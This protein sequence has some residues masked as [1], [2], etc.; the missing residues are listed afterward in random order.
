MRAAK[1]IILAEMKRHFPDMHQKPEMPLPGTNIGVQWAS[2]RGLTISGY[3]SPRGGQIYEEIHDV[4]HLREISGKM[5]F[6]LRYETQ[7]TLDV[8]RVVAN[9]LTLFYCEKLSL[10]MLD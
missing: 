10:Y 8:D 6:S 4:W 7:G 1:H 2:A 5:I 3:I 9:L